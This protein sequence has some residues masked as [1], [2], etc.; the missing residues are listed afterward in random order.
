[1]ITLAINSLQKHQWWHEMEKLYTWC[2]SSH[3]ILDCGSPRHPQTWNSYSI[4]TL[5]NA[6][7]MFLQTGRTEIHIITYVHYYLATKTRSA[8][9]LFTQRYHSN[10]KSILQLFK[11]FKNTIRYHSKNKQMANGWQSKLSQC[12]VNITLGFPS[13]FWL[14]VHIKII[15]FKCTVYKDYYYEIRHGT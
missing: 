1:M 8:V 5:K 6:G 11:W 10:C 14:P 7:S 4:S 3:F 15:T 9:V 2:L 12:K 13:L